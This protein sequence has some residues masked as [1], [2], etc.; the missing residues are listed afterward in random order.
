MDY[1]NN[2][3]LTSQT[4]IGLIH[5]ITAIIGLILG[6]GILFL[7]PG[8]KS[9]KIAG[10]FFIPI[11]LTVNISAL[12]IHEM[13]MAFGP[14]HFLIPFSLYYLFLGVKP[15]LSKNTSSIKIKTH[16]KGMVGA[17]LGLWAAFFAELV[18]RTPIISKLLLPIG[19]NIFWIGTIEGFA[20]VLIFIFIIQK[21][22][23]RQ[24]KRLN[25]DI[26]K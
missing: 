10:Y 12:Y 3:W 11:L 14:F 15:F 7:R 21:V 25:L 8:S 23:I 6:L 5:F 19:K 9:H 13:G 18:A 26:E 16:I 1:I 4:A 2:H 20:F 17:A 22:N 24:Y